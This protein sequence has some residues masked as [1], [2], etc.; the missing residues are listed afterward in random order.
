MTNL[1]IILGML[2]GVTILLICV[3][4]DLFYKIKEILYEILRTLKKLEED[5]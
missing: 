2:I 3:A 1:L 4:V 5:E